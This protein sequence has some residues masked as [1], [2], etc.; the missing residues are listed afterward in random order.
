MKNAL[1]KIQKKFIKTTVLNETVI[2]D[3]VYRVIEKTSFLPWYQNRRA[4]CFKSAEE[5]KK[6]Y[7]HSMIYNSPKVHYQPVLVVPQKVTELWHKQFGAKRALVLGA[8]GCTVPRFIALNFPEMQTVGIEY[9]HEFVEIANKYFLLS[10]INDRFTLIEGDAFDYVINRKFTEKQ[11][12]IFVDVFNSLSVPSEVFSEEF[13][14]RLYEE[15]NS[16]SLVIINLLTLKKDAAEDFA[17]GIKTPF[18]KKA[19]ILNG[20][21]VTLLLAKSEDSEKMKG[22]FENINIFDSLEEF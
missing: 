13:I 18:D 15:T 3:T 4:I 6:V 7:I 1:R 5:P 22:F 14:N 21:T 8:A 10:Q 17:N 9:C 20:Q 2:G 12:I 19:L 16:D 11:D